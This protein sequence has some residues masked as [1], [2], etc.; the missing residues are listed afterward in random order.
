MLRSLVVPNTRKPHSLKGLPT[1]AHPGSQCCTQSRPT[2][3]PHFLFRKKTLLKVKP[4][5]VGPW[6]WGRKCAAS[7]PGQ[8]SLPLGCSGRLDLPSAQAEGSREGRSREGPLNLTTKT[9]PGNTRATD[10]PPGPG[11]GGPGH[12]PASSP[13]QG[14]AGNPPGR[15]SV[16]AQAELQRSATTA[17][18][19]GAGPQHATDSRQSFRSHMADKTGE[20]SPFL[21]PLYQ[22]LAR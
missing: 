1:P 3:T 11:P 5:G 2:S 17:E 14:H 22:D 8:E 4:R 20:K 18:D 6:G 21:R 15:A 9:A 10:A 12:P 13:G 19:Q 7:E 16:L